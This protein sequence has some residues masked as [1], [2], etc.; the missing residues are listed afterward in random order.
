MK[1]SIATTIVI[2]IVGAVNA[3]EGTKTGLRM[4]K[5]A[6]ARGEPQ[7]NTCVS[8]DSGGIGEAVVPCCTSLG[9]PGFVATTSNKK[10]CQNICYPCTATADKRPGSKKSMVLLDDT[11]FSNCNLSYYYCTYG[12]DVLL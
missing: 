5:G 1:L 10:E 2:A 3:Q 11:L 7:L 4:L 8:D 9:Q 12:L 6:K